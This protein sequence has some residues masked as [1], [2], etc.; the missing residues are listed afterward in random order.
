MDEALHYVAR[1]LDEGGQNPKPVLLHS[2]KVSMSLY[3]LGYGRDIVL[4][5]ILHDLIEDTG[6]TREDIAELYGEEIAGIIAAVSFDAG[7]ED[8]LEQAKDM[9]GRC[10]SF[11][12]KALIVKCA[13][14]L[15]NIAFVHLPA[16]AEQE[17][18][19]RKYSLFLEISEAHIGDE[20]IYGQLAKR[21]EKESRAEA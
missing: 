6:T 19:L 18:L 5:A 14:L 2:F 21:F 8:V 17:K 7:I 4:S 13:D 20:P 9:F 11:G 1:R 10:I 15:D 3:A 16:P 12:R